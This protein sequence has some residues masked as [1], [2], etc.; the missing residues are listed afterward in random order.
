MF[1]NVT[2][3]YAAFWFRVRTN[4]KP[5]F[6]PPG[7]GILVSNHTCSADAPFLLAG[8]MRL[9]SFLVAREHF[10]I[11]RPI[12]NLLEWLD[13]VPVSR[14][15]QDVLA[16]RTALRRLREGRLIAIFPE[17]NLRGIA[18]DR[19][20][21]GRAGVALLAL[22]SRMP[23]YPVF[24]AG[25]PRTD[26][27]LKSWLRLSKSPVRLFFGKPIDLSAYYGR[28]LR[29]KLLEEVTKYIMSHI[30]ALEPIPKGV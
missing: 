2:R 3:C 13:C 23:V 15:G 6:P 14:T 11:V 21:S 30:A 7:P 25:G 5:P 4:V 12:Q 28:P 29:R 8:T 24:I 26:R 27:L 1:L 22:R 20:R 9:I 17:G 10:Y 18:Q 19:M 16:A